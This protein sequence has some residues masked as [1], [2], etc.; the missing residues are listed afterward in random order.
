MNGWI[1]T[2]V[3][4]PTLLIE[5]YGFRFL[6][7]PTFDPSGVEYTTGPVTLRKTLG[8]HLSP[9]WIGSV[10]AVLL[11]HDQHEDNLDARGRAFL[12]SAGT[13]LT[14]PAGAARLGGNA[15]GL[16]AFEE[17][18]IGAVKVVATPARHGPEG[19]EP[20]AGDVTGFLLIPEAN[21]M[22]TLYV[23]GDTLPFAGTLEIAR[24]APRTG[25]LFTGGAA[26]DAV[27]PDRLTMG[28]IEAAEMARDLGLELVVP[29][30]ADGWA[31]LREAPAEFDEAFGNAT[32][33]LRLIP[34]EATPLPPVS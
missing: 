2:L 6:T 24:H 22:D 30:H 33:L 4:G 23:S 8:P 29:I 19:I 31:H 10:D 25:V 21:P 13:V 18:T 1:L 9:D 32:P 17:R 27:G 5:G 3:G 28:G 12:P 20:V 11:S 34:G 26:L 14:T 7:D 16:A 15:L